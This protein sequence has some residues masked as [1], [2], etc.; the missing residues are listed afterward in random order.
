[1]PTIAHLCLK[2]LQ[3]GV[4]PRREIRIGKVMLE[5][6]TW[7][8]NVQYDMLCHVIGSANMTKHLSKNKKL[9][10]KIIKSK[11]TPT[12]S[13]YAKGKSFIDCKCFN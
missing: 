12:S 10:T 4:T 11:K 6:N 1:M 5:L 3:K 8:L 7:A 13:A 9:L 2:L